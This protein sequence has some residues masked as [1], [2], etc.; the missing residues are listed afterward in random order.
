MC[1]D[2]AKDTCDRCSSCRWKT[3]SSWNHVGYIKVLWKLVSRNMGG[4]R[5]PLGRATMRGCHLCIAC[6]ALAGEPKHM[7]LP[8]PAAHVVAAAAAVPAAAAAAGA[9]VQACRADNT[10]ARPS[11]PS[12]SRTH[13]CWASAIRSETRPE[14]RGSHAAKA[15]I[16]WTACSCSTADRSQLTTLNT[17]T[18]QW[19]LDC[20]R[21]DLTAVLT[22]NMLQMSAGALRLGQC[23][24][25]SCSTVGAT[26]MADRIVCQYAYLGVHDSERKGDGR[27]TI[28]SYSYIPSAGKGVREACSRTNLN[29]ATAVQSSCWIARRAATVHGN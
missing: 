28:D 12:F 19:P 11:W 16:R 1:L 8:A 3:G 22:C 13:R 24:T 2:P 5:P 10:M 15:F 6:A 17:S 18:L 27:F 25:T 14:C 26:C 29:T 4:F 23:C 9:S 20:C 7:L 21:A